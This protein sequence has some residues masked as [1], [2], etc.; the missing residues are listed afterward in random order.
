MDFKEIIGKLDNF[1]RT[2]NKMFI[3]VAIIEGI[4]VTCIGILSNTLTTANPDINKYSTYLIIFFGLLYLFLLFIRT[5]YSTS[6]PSSITNELKSERELQELK[7]DAERQKTI[8]EFF[9][10]TM[11]RL[12][13]QT[14]ALNIGDGTH[15]C[16]IGISNGIHELIEPVIDN[17]YFLLDTINTKFTIGVFLDGYRSMTLYNQLERGIIVIDDKLTKSSFLIKE[18][19]DTNTVRTE[20][21]ELQTAIRQCFNNSEFVD[22]NYN[23][24]QNDFSIVCSPMPSACNE[25]DGLGVLFII[26]KKL[27]T[28]PTDLPTKLKIFGRVIANWIYRYNECVNNRQQHIQ[29]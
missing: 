16:D 12:N 27:E 2:I 20:Q 4:V 25:N 17:T 26:S 1:C 18:L 5:A 3:V 23:D 19:L 14:C 15:L 11:Q 29:N 22:K 10:E 9:V 6:F 24:G 13:G 7:R 21:L 8:N 28:I